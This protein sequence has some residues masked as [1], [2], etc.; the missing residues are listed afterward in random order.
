MKVVLTMYLCSL[1][2]LEC[3]TPYTF[4]DRYNDLYS[5][6]LS[7][8]EK[9]YDKVKEIGKKDLNS[10]MLF[11]KFRCTQVPDDEKDA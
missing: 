5:C 2:Q 7:G 11:I 1:I 10:D 9:A 6:M 8:Y 4:P 3:I